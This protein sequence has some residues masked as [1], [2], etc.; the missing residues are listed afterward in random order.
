MKCC[1]NYVLSSRILSLSLSCVVLLVHPLCIF[2][3]STSGC[4]ETKLST[5]KQQQISVWDQNSPVCTFS[6]YYYYYHHHHRAHF[7]RVHLGSWAFVSYLYSSGLIFNKLRDNLR[8]KCCFTNAVTHS[9][10][11]HFTINSLF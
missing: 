6:D 8:Y 3:G 7:R 10:A 5:T 4:W 11:E 9:S 1:N 2:R